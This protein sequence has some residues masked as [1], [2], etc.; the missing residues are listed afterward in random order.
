MQGIAITVVL[1]AGVLLGGIRYGY[2]RYLKREEKLSPPFPRL[3][4]ERAASNSECRWLQLKK[5]FYAD[6]MGKVREW[7]KAQRLTRREGCEVDGVMVIA[8]IV[9]GSRDGCV[10]F[11]SQFRPAV[12]RKTLEL[13]AGLVDAGETAET[14]AIRELREETGLE[15]KVT[16]VSPILFLD[17]GM[18]SSAMRCVTVMVDGTNPKNASPVQQLDHGEFCEVLYLK[19]PTR[20]RINALGKELAIDANVYICCL[21]D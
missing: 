2:F 4:S 9:G 10:P 18:S 1:A 6:D 17:P 11:V 12:G 13:P 3:L 5:V 20:E 21:S 15:G 8:K 19:N 14:A 7:E 16:S